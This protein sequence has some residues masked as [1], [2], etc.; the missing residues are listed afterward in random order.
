ML[1]GPRRAGSA[2]LG[3]TP[4]RR[5]LKRS[6]AAGAGFAAALRVPAPAVRGGAL[7][8]NERIRLGCIGVGNRGSELIERLLA[9]EDAEIVALA[10]VYRPYLE[11]D[12]SKVDPRLVEELGGRI[13]QMREPLPSVDG[14]YAD[15]RRLLDRR[16]VDAVVIA[17]PDHWHA[18][19]T[20]AACEAGKDV[21][22]EKPLSATIAEGRKMV[23]AAKRTGRIVEVGLQRRSSSLFASLAAEV[24]GGLIGRVTVARAYRIDDMSPKGIG[25]VEDAE[26]PPGL[27]WDMW[28][29][30]R[31]WRPYRRNIAPYKF[32]W[33]KEYSSQVANWGVHYF[34]AIRWLLAEEA[35]SAVSAHGGRFAID[36]DR[37]I[38]DTLEATFEMASG[39]LIAFGQYEAS[40]GAA[41]ASGEI[42]LRGTEANVYASE[43]AYTLVPASAGQFQAPRPRG[44][45]KT[46]RGD[47]QDT[48]AAHLRDF[49]DCVRSRG[50]PRCDLE[51]GHRSTTFALLANIALETRARIEWDPA[52]EKI[53]SPLE[54]NRLLEYEYRKPWS[55]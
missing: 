27:D 53:R 43:S 7:G 28:L 5:F 40:G 4:R 13:P 32:R 25:K 18:I 33:W 2:G 34:D 26:P 54:A 36:D 22:V 3:N 52:A 37:D 15:F 50:R 31:A 47:G 11:R 41:L 30:P 35:P 55:L 1:R 6:I 49:L 20:I 8:A 29:G 38:P 44:D 21:Y 48:T 9:F 19:Q 39:R 17:T 14:R 16:D 23:E 12:R 24:A 46:V 51:T 45:A 10:D 42:E